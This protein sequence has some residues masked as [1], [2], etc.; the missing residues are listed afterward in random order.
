M[1]RMVPPTLQTERLILRPHGLED[2]DAYAEMLRT[3]DVGV[4]SGLTSLSR[5]QAWVR[6][7][8]GFGFWAMHARGPLGVIEKSTGAYVGEVGVADFERDITPSHCHMPEFFWAIT[9]AARGRGFASEAVQKMTLW[10]DE[11][12]AENTFCCLI[13]EDNLPSQNVARKAGFKRAYAASYQGA[14]CGVYVRARC[15]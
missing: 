12:C 10:A 8:R 6:F 13:D 2:F 5:E 4:T 7:L 11:N 9:L 15:V 1:N 3:I 14:E